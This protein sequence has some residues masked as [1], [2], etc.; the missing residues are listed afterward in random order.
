MHLVKRSPRTMA[1]KKRSPRTIAALVKKQVVSALAI[2]VAQVS[3]SHMFWA[4]RW[5]RGPTTMILAGQLPNLS[6]LQDARL[7]YAGGLRQQ[8]F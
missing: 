5:L 1:L 2:L 6:C 4:K 8:N 3:R 7:C